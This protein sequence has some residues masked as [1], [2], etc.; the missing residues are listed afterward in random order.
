VFL[1]HGL[2]FEFVEPFADYF[3]EALLKTKSKMKAMARAMV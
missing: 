1:D 3:Q 2:T